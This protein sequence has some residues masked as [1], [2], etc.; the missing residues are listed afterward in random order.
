M[1]IST[2]HT[3]ERAQ[4]K[5]EATAT[6]EPFYRRSRV[7]AASPTFGNASSCGRRLVGSF[8]A[9]IAVLR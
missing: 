6:I 2:E 4:E 7:K 5:S 3:A 9:V 8:V 1:A